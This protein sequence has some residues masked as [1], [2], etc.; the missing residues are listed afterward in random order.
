MAADDPESTSAPQGAA[1]PPAAAGSQASPGSQGGP[2]SQAGPGSRASPGPQAAAGLSGGP[3]PAQDEVV[4][5]LVKA[6]ATLPDAER[7]V[8]YAWFLNRGIT[9]SRP[10]SFAGAGPLPRQLREMSATLL[11]L[12]TAGGLPGAQPTG[13]Q[14]VPVRFAADQH[15]ALRTWCSEHGFSMATV[16]RGLVAR[17]LEGQLPARS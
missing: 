14:V 12:Q 13:Q 3:E 4:R 1:T 11:S 15:A 9:G 2:G 17:F 6:V 16:I 8:V 10:S 5:L 7:D